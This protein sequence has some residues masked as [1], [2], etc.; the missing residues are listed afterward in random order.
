MAPEVLQTRAGESYSLSPTADVWSMGIVIYA[1][2][3]L[4]LP[5]TEATANDHM[6]TDFVEEANARSLMR[7]KHSPAWSLM[8]QNL[9]AAMYA[10][11][12]AHEMYRPPMS[13][14]VKILKGPWHPGPP[15]PAADGGLEPVPLVDPMLSDNAWMVPRAPR[16]PGLPAYGPQLQRS[17]CTT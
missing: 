15:P 9:R 2:L 6:Y 17:N 14:V 1:V 13:A 8:H 10:M 5:W 7:A 12:D 11:L 3:V 16:A 4:A